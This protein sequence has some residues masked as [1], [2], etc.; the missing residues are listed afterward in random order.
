MPT[1]TEGSNVSTDISRGAFTTVISAITSSNG[2]EA[3]TS[4]PQEP[5]QSTA[6]VDNTS[7]EP[8]TGEGIRDLQ[9]VSTKFTVTDSDQNKLETTAFT[10]Q[11]MSETTAAKSVVTSTTPGPTGGHTGI[12]RHD[13]QN[14]RPVV[15]DTYCGVIL[16]FQFEASYAQ[17]Y[18]EF[19]ALL[20]FYS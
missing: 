16:A 6:R 12:Y 18:R 14:E 10:M 1:T 3:P 8:A 15:K 13:N 5:V 7:H 9:E 4:H 2:E 17:V 19:L 11:E 20:I